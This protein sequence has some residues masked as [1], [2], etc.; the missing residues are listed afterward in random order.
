MII[1]QEYGEGVELYIRRVVH[2]VAPLQYESVR[3]VKIE[4]RSRYAIYAYDK[5]CKLITNTGE[6]TNRQLEETC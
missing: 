4:N 6:W 1:K 3:V 5:R 2:A